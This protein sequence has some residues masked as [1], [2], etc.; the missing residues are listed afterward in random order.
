MGDRAYALAPVCRPPVP[1]DPAARQRSPPLS[2]ITAGGGKPP[3]VVRPSSGHGSWRRL[4]AEVGDVQGRLDD[5]KRRLRELAD[6]A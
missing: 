5:L 1:E 4:L 3:S 2:A 6:G